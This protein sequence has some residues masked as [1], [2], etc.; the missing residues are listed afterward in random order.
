[1][2]LRT[3]SFALRTLLWL[4]L[5]I[6]N[7]RVW[8]ICALVHKLDLGLV[9]IM[10]VVTDVITAAVTHAASLF[11]GSVMPF[12]EFRTKERMSRNQV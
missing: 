7:M 5:M 6:G 11:S 4:K 3:P 8:I 9:V 2:L 1:M 12:E 10:E